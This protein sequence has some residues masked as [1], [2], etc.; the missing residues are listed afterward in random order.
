M[1]KGWFFVLLVLLVFIDI[2]LSAAV[3]VDAKKLKAPALQVAPGIW[4][5]LSF[6]FPFFGF[7]IYWLMNRSSLSH[8]HRI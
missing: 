1:I 6:L 2:Y 5:L 3:Y 8:I 4:G 7:F